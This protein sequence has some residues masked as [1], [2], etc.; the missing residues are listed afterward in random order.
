M[1]GSTMI[2]KGEIMDKLAATVCI[3]GGL[4]LLLLGCGFFMSALERIV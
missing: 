3:F 1:L 4:A 2:L